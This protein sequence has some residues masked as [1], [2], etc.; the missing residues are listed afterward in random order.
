MVTINDY[1]AI[2]EAINTYLAGSNAGK[3]DLMRAAFAEEA[4]MQGTNKDGSVV[5]GSIENLYKVIDA[6]GKTESTAHI[7]VLHISGNIASVRV[8]IEGWHGL[9]FVD[10]H[11][12]FKQNGKWKIVAKA[13]HTY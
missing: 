2:T 8:V 4:I 12:L 11:Q 13:Y 6:S 3:S 10:L 7:D 9:N 5:S 1:E